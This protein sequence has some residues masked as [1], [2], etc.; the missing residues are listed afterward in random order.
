MFKKLI[1]KVSKLLNLS[2]YLNRDI[3]VNFFNQR[4]FSSLDS[5]IEKDSKVIVSLTTYGVRINTV[6]LTIESLGF[7]SLK[8]NRI[9]LWLDEN[10]FTLGSL[11]L[12]LKKLQARGL[13]IHFCKNIKSYKKLIPTLELIENCNIV[14]VDDDILYPYGF[15]DHFM[16]EN[17][18]TKGACVLSYRAHK[19]TFD[20][21]NNILPYLKWQHE[22]RS[23]DERLDLTPTGNLGVFYPAGCFDDEVKDESKFME[24]APNADDLW[25][26]VMTLRKGIKC[27]VIING[28]YSSNDFIELPNDYTNSL[29]FGNVNNGGNDRQ[30]SALDEVYNIKEILRKNNEH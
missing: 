19:I 25:F 30:L 28:R 17:E 9:L 2:N 4:N 11:P 18:L 5:L 26:K 27:K 22:Y 21:N 8:P 1:E 12:S 16:I 20:N 15:L 24:Y 14:T 10:E 13:E 29:G 6:Y 23:T 3:L 7:Q